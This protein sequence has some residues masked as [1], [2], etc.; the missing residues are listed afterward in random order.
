VCKKGQKSTSTIKQK[1]KSC[2][3]RLSHAIRKSNQ[4]GAIRKAMGGGGRGAKIKIAQGKQ[5]EKKS[6]TK[7]V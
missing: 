4:V 7:E 5:K 6:C 1:S 2:I 3:F